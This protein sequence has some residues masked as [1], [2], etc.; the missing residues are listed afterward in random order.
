MIVRH[1]IQHT[2][3]SYGYAYVYSYVGLQQH[4]AGTLYY[5]HSTAHI[6]THQLIIIMCL[7]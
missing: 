3:I 7:Y 2:S 5:E 1:Q 6:K 4:H